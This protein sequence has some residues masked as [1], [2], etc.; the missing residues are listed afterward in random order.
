MSKPQ[1][2][3]ITRQHLLDVGLTLFSKRGFHG[4]GIKEIV[5]QAKVPKGSF[6]TYFKSKEEFG[7]EIIKSHSIDFWQKWYECFDNTSADPLDALKNCFVTLLEKYEV[8]S[9]KMFCAV[10]LIAAEICETSDLCR[11]TTATIINDMSS[12]LAIQ[13]VK[14]QQKGYARTDTDAQEMAILFWDAWQGSIV[15]MKIEN[16]ST[17]VTNC[18]S[19]FFDK[20]FRI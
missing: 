15:R 7:V 11:T 14:A 12:N 1:K 18:I 13:I 4:T 6:Y 2:T 9:V 19:L 10:A 16:N 8:L 5:D 17:P 20:L 3:E